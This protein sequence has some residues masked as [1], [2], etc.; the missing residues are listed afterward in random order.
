[1]RK[2]ILFLAPYPFGKAPSQRFRF[3]QYMDALRAAGIDWDFDPFIDEKTWQILYQPGHYLSKAW[4]IVRAFGRRVGLVLSGL[5]DYDLIFIHREATHIG[6]PVIEWLIAKVLKKKIVYDF[7]DAIWLPNYSV[8]NR[9][10]HRLKMYGKVRHL[11]RWAWRIAAGN[12]YLCDFARQYNAD[13]VRLPTTIDTE[14]HHNRLHTPNTSRPVIGWTGTLTTTRYLNMLLPVIRELEEVYDF[15]F[16]V[17]ANEDPHFDCKSFRFLAWNKETE[18]EDLLRFDIGLMPLEDDIWAKGKCGFKA[19]QY[20]ALGVPALVSPVGVNTEIVTH[21]Q[22]GYV[23]ET[24][25]AWKEALT[26][27]LA[28]PALRVR[29][30]QAARRTVEERYSVHANLNQFLSL[31]A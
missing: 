14:H 12:P 21:G 1:M 7:D 29:M 5:S 26:Q 23:C 16:C 6:P 30:G 19:L 13:V 20:M 9:H 24:A 11:M 31:F 27:L 3:E 15:E 22:D 2:K 18:I 25:S 28:D 4:G 10:F 8:H 17:I